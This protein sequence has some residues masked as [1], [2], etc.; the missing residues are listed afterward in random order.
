MRILI[1]RSGAYGDHLHIS[2][3]PRLLKENG[4]TFLG[5]SMNHKGLQLFKHNPFIDKIHFFDGSGR[6]VSERYYDTRL[7]IL[8]QDYDKVIDFGL[9]L[10]EGALA[11]ERQNIY[12]QHI[13]QRK[14]I[15]ERNYYDIATVHAGFPEL[16]GKYKGEIFYTK[17]EE[18]LVEHDL[19]RPGRFKD[20]DDRCR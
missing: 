19:L 13:N 20:K 18:N 17:E 8:A 1:H 6:K 7:R 4:C 12:Y 14:K 15:G 10:E 9:T 3:I 16:C 11:M 2:H 5:F